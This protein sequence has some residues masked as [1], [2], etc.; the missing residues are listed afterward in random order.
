M[1]FFSFFLKLIIDIIKTKTDKIYTVKTTSSFPVDVTSNHPFLTREMKYETYK[2][3]SGK[4]RKRKTFGNPIW[5]EVS[6][7]IIGKDYVGI[8]I[9]QES[10]IPKG[11]DLPFNSD[12][13]WWFIGRYIGD[14]WTEVKKHKNKNTS[15]RYEEKVVLSC[16]KK[17]KEKELIQ[18]V[19]NELGFKYWLE[20]AGA[21]YKFNIYEQELFDYLQEFGQYAYGKKLNSDVLNL[22]IALTEKFLI[23]YF[24]ADGYW[25]KKENRYSIKTVSKNLAIGTMQ[26]I[27]KIGRASCRER[28]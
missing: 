22:P 1:L 11:Y 20:N 5:K 6:E 21:T 17:E 15:I 2:N 28:V 16:P 26:I 23:G 12:N 25:L 14:G 3:E 4:W 27:H 7:L 8:P 9:N 24:S 18:N 10:I 13:F 19:L